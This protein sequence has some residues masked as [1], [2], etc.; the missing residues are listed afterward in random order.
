M[1]KL[2][3]QQAEY[4]LLVVSCWLLVNFFAL[5]QKSIKAQQSSYLIEFFALEVTTNIHEDI[6]RG[7]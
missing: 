1:G 4:K 2:F 5:A 6:G 3:G 7:W